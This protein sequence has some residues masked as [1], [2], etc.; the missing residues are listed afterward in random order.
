MYCP[1][2][3]K[4]INEG[5]IFCSGCGS[6]IQNRGNAGIKKNR[7]W[8]ALVGIILSMVCLALII[9]GAIVGYRGMVWF[10]ERSSNAVENTSAEKKD[11]VF[12]LR[13]E[14]GNI[15]MT[16]GVKN[17]VAK[18]VEGG[19]GFT[20]FVVEIQLTDSAS[21]EFERITEEHIDENIG[22]Y[23]NDDMIANPRIVS[24]I[25]EG[26]CNVTTTTY[27]EAVTLAEL[28]NSTK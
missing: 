28:L 6:Q 23:L 16:G 5:D 2:C 4:L 12:T 3:G 7:K 21:K 9:S 15:L 22:I 27:E 18:T 10:R 11:N 17:A 14:D 25:A 1:K 8:R 13:D 19:Y 24:A 26:S 20:M